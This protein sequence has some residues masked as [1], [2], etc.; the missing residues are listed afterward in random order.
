MHGVC[1]GAV[2]V[3]VL[4]VGIVLVFVLALVLLGSRVGAGEKVLPSTILGNVLGWKDMLSG[5]ERRTRRDW[6]G[7]GDSRGESFVAMTVVAVGSEIGLKNLGAES[8]VGREFVVA[9]VESEMYE[10]RR[11]DIWLVSVSA[12]GLVD[13]ATRSEVWREKDMLGGLEGGCDVLDERLL[14]GSRTGV[15]TTESADLVLRSDSGRRNDIVLARRRAGLFCFSRLSSE[16]GGFLISGSLF[17]SFP[18]LSEAK[19][20]SPRPNTT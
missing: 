8:E 16:G 5:R 15:S 2:L 13:R 19:Y 9:D 18:F 3:V 4:V 10:E 17:S 1:V 14:L 6:I 12:L 11:L 20:S 7:S